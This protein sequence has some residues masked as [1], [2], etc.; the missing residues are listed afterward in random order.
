MKALSP[1]NF[2]LLALASFVV[3]RIAGAADIERPKVELVD[4]LRV[5]VATGQVTH[6]LDTVS[7]GGPMGLAHGVSIHANEFNF[8]RNFGFQ[9]RYWSQPRYVRI[10]QSTTHPIPNVLRIS[11]MSGSADF[12]VLVNGNPVREFRNTLPPYTYVAIGDE[13][14]T[15]AQDADALAWIKP[16]GTVVKFLHGANGPAGNVGLMTQVIAPN[17][18]MI[19][20]DVF[21]LESVQTN[22]GFQLKYL[23]VPDNR[24]MDKPDNPNLINA[25][26]VSTSFQSGWSNRNARYVTAINNAVEYCAPSATTCAFTNAWPTAT[27][28]WPAGMPRAIFI[29][30]SRATITDAAGAVAKFD[31]RAYDLCC[32]EAGVV[33]PY[34]PGREFSP[35][36]IGVTA[37]G[38]ARPTFVYDFKN[39]FLPESEGIF[40]TWTSRAQTAGVIKTATNI[41]RI[42][43][44]SLMQPYTFG[45][46]F[47]YGIGGGI[48]RVL[49]SPPAAPGNPDFISYA[50]TEDGIV[51]FESSARNFPVRFER[52]SGPW[53]EYEYTRGNLTRVMVRVDG[54]WRVHREA[55]YP[56]SCTP[57]T[58]KT[59][60]QAEWIRD[61]NGGVTYYTY[62]PA[63][64]QIASV[65][66]PANKNG[67][68]AQTRYEYAQLSAHYFNG[69][70]SR[71]AGAPIWMKTAERYCINSNYAGNACAA[72]DEVI[73]RYEYD[74]DNLLL[75]GMTVT[76]PATGQMRR[77]C[78]Q[79]DI[80]GNQI[81]VTQ[82]MA[83]LASC[84]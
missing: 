76:D 77:T 12:R 31:F 24:P 42:V 46:Y 56:A 63:S 82:P 29:G 49:L 54:E 61:P 8:N 84:G 81:G 50:E 59:C 18:F 79:Y 10:S 25:P 36:L 1:E 30:Q 83:K 65:T 37:F 74:H 43:N 2:A 3:V 80:Y 52:L 57:A 60:N 4:K 75:T 26:Q 40:G 15:L 28:D 23:Y 17:G 38:S 47:N 67:I 20:I 45:A 5:N 70:A 48:N 32:N 44:Y 22:T 33:E 53:E 13:R 51:R 78:Y 64:G 7:I 68:V 19:S 41:D 6:S 9:D 35:R 21:G 27:F 39:L 16:D 34:A 11:D 58:R 55:G 72:N 66:Y 69:G 14:H 62:H 73:T 71:I